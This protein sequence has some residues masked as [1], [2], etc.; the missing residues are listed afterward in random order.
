M[1]LC[2]SHLAEAHHQP[3][4][5]SNLSC[6]YY[7]SLPLGQTIP[8]LEVQGKRTEQTEGWQQMVSTVS[9]K[10]KNRDTVL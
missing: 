3:Y 4:Q 1:F 9:A 6:S 2:S 7:L 10:A 5:T 8:F